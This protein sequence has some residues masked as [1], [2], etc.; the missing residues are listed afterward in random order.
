MLLAYGHAN[1]GALAA[2]PESAATTL[3]VRSRLLLV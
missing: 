2:K 3:L 1:T